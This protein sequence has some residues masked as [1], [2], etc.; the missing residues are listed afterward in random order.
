MP[1]FEASCS[2]A[3]LAAQGGCDERH[4]VNILRVVKFLQGLANGACRAVNVHGVHAGVA[5]GE[6]LVIVR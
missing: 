2:T 6:A 1:G 3:T 5:V 4:A